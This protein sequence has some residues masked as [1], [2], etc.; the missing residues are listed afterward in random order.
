MSLEQAPIH[1]KI[2]VDLIMILEDSAVDTDDVLKALKL[3]E[4]DFEKK[5]Q[6][7]VQNKL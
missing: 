6:A 7:M 1:I 3:V 5:K 2:A 4:Q